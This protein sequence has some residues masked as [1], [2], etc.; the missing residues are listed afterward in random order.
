MTFLNRQIRFTASI[1]R[2]FLVGLILGVFLSFVIIVLQPFDTDQFHSDHK[3]LVL[4]IFGFLFFAAFVIYSILEN[5]WYSRVRK[6]W[7][8]YHEISSI[9]LFFVFVGSVIFLYNSL[10]INQQQYSVGNHL[11][12]LRTIVLAMTPVLAPLT[13]YLRQR[14]GERIVPIPASS[15]L[16]I[17]E[18][19][20]EV[21]NLEKEDLLFV[22]AVENY[23]EIC[24]LDEHKT[25]LSK[26]FRQTLSNVERQI[27]FLEKCHRSYLVNRSAIKEISGNS[28]SAKISFVYGEEKIPLSKTYYK[29]VK[30]SLL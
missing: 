1:K 6:T 15:I 7:R 24:F 5:F 8:V 13:I 11:L 2:K 12:Y 21:L 18:N 25:V 30:A 9:I 10:L 28:Q 23:V 27:P 16:L 17:G 20:N 19:K 14:F 4:S 29:Q 26:T 3:L 22:K